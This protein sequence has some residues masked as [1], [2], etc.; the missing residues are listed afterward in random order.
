MAATLTPTTIDRSD[1]RTVVTGGTKLG[2]ITAGAVVLYLLVAKH[3]PAGAAQ[4][5]A[6]AVLVL[7][8]GFAA[9]LLPGYW[10]AAR[11]VE[12]IAG[13]AAV[14]LWGSVVF[15]A[16]DIAVLRPLHA[17]PWTWD[18][19]GG[20]SSWWYLPMWWIL[21]TFL[22]W[23]GGVRIAA[24]AARGAPSV[25]RAATPAAVGAIVL[26]AV[27]HA[28]VPQ[29]ALPVAAGAALALTLLA[30]GAVSLALRT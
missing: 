27:A 20:G 24:Q 3:V 11:N 13:A 16:I 12:G 6:Q 25:I 28:V 2:L 15:A 23:M 19:I 10:C 18:A 9:A 7:G 14:G 21:G 29:V 5:V 1:F 22:A 26:A 17:Y 30:L 4:S 8:A